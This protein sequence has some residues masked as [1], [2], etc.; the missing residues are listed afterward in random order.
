MIMRLLPLLVFFTSTSLTAQDRPRDCAVTLGAFRTK[1][2]QNYAGFHLEVVG[3]RRRSH[4]SLFRT[5][6]DE[7]KGAAGESCFFVLDRYVKWFDD[8][9]LFVFQSTR[10]DTAESARR[11]TQVQKVA[12]DEQAAKARLTGRTLDPIEG[13][14]YDGQGLRIAILPDS[15]LRDRFMAVVVT[16]DSAPWPV[17]SVRG[18]IH[19]RGAND[20][21]VDLYARNFALRHLSGVIHKEV[22]LRLSPGMFAREYPAPEVAGLVDARVPQRPTLVRRNGTVIVSMTSHDPAYRAVVDSLVNA[23]R[24]AL[25]MAEHLIIDLRG[26]EGGGAFTSA[27]LTPYIRSRVTRRHRYQSDTSW[28]LSSPDQIAYTRRAFGSDT[29]LFVRTLLARL[30]ESPGRLVPM[31]PFSS[32]PSPDTVVLG[33]SRV[34]ILVDG[35]TVSAAEVVVLQALQSTRALVFGQPTDGALDYSSANVVRVLPDES[36]WLLGYGTMAWSNRLPVNGMREKGIE[37]DVRIAIDRLLSPIE[38]VQRLLS[39]SR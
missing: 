10:L 1:I 9:H 30:D 28:M 16:S 23:N 20:Y 3:E 7:A 21:L 4:D 37:P 27:A 31:P 26:N 15:S 6:T 19:K 13:I 29:S 32:P 5:L 11:A 34:G 18:T 38:S 17:G 33:P 14:W 25:G 2:E 24:E 35:G 22:I 36:R 8:P 12:I 39:G